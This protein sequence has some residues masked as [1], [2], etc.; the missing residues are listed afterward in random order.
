LQFLLEELVF[1]FPLFIKKQ[2]GFIQFFLFLIQYSQA[3]LE[4]LLILK[5]EFLL[6]ICRQHVFHIENRGTVRALYIG[7][8]PEF[9]YKLKGFL[10]LLALG[11]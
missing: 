3:L 5:L 11:G 8:H 9:F 6:H 2:L 10:K 1:L 7:R 4:L